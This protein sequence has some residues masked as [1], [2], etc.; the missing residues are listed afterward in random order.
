MPG[1]YERL[2]QRAREVCV[3]S[4]QP[5]H[6]PLFWFL[7]GHT[8]WARKMVWCVEVLAAKSG[9]RVQSLGATWWRV[10]NDSCKLASDL[11]I[12]TVT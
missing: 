4:F 6:S 1:G 2:A 12:L 9:A 3:V 8:Q 11:H 7:T 5:S 10:R